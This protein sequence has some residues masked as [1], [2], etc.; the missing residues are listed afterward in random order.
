L[1]VYISANPGLEILFIKIH[2][3][4]EPCIRIKLSTN[5]EKEIEIKAPVVR[6]HFLSRKKIHPKY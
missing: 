3:K 4:T 2:Q 1:P 6:I 5:K